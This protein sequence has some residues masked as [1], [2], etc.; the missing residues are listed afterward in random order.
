MVFMGVDAV[1]DNAPLD[2]AADADIAEMEAAWSNSGFLN[3]FVQ[4][5]ENG[6]ARRRHIGVGSWHEVPPEQ[7][8]LQGGRALANFVSTSLRAVDHQATDHSMLVLWGH[9]YDFAVGPSI[10]G[11][12]NVDAL[13]F[14]ELSAVLRDLQNEMWL[15]Y[16]GE[17]PPRLNIVAF[18]A[19]D[20]STV[21][22]ACQLSPFAKYLLA[23]QI[24]VPIPG[25]P[26]DRIFERFGDPIG[27][28]MGPAQGGAYIVRRYCE[29]Y[30]SLRPVSLS[31]L[32]LGRAR[33]LFAR[34]EVLATA[35]DL[36]IRRNGDTRDQ[37]A[38]LFVR[39]QTA[40]NKPY[41][42][43]ADFCLNLF[44]ESTD[45]FV[46][47][48]AQALGDFL[49]TSGPEVATLSSEG[50]G[51]PFIAEWGRNAGSTARLNGV[52][53]YAPH[54]A[55]EHDSHAARRIYSQFDFVRQ[56]RWSQLVYALAD[57]T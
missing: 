35:L 47:A 40:P 51:K 55:R 15:E 57:R 10:T 5:H 44:R 4:R 17:E 11:S 53:I 49:V 34:T 26:Y 29:S 41:V 45:A 14:V 46:I 22:L 13:E 32:D 52:S 31:L 30:T 21:E 56:T 18:D 36:S 20:A 48:A 3:I 28:V 23:S 39:A 25:W 24:G 12:G 37:V 1:G 19:C 9:A 27:D 43:V 6:V 16:P 7:S 33:E 42:D 50:T 54:V 8:Q 38:N 2:I